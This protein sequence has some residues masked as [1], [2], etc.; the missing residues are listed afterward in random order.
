MHKKQ[1]G[2]ALTPGHFQ[3]CVES[4]SLPAL[5]GHIFASIRN[6]LVKK[7]WSPLCKYLDFFFNLGFMSSVL[8]AA[9]E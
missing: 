2:G 7:K 4:F 5:T 9:A 8:L 6:L 1:Q 3:L